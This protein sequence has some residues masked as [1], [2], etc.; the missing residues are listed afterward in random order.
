MATTEPPNTWVSQPP[1]TV[2]GKPRTWWV[3]LPAN[4][5]PAR[6]YPLVFTFQGCGA[7]DNIVPMQKV[8]GANAI[9]VRAATNLANNC[10]NY[11]ATGDDVLFF[12]ALLKQLT[13]SRCIDTGRVFAA[14]YS[15]GSWLIN[16][17]TC[18]RGD[19]FRAV[20][21]VS[22][23]T[24]GK[25]TCVGKFARTF[26]HDADDTDKPHG[27]ESRGANAAAGAKS[28]RHDPRSDPGSACPV[29]ALPRLRPR[30]SHHHVP[31]HDEE[32]RPGGQHGPRR[33]LGTVLVA[34][35]CLGLAFV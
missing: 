19:K 7:T 30:L 28:L 18:V 33:V 31:D 24:G 20:G 10:Y 17:L 4:Y 15:S 12:D 2:N 1:L 29:R 8:T 21:T 3:W 5:N 27:R 25:G 6:A 23:G 11:S 13:A 16:T 9:V 32:A 26:I 35:G 34:L 22:G 14:G